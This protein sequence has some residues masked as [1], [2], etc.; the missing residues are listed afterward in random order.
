MDCVVNSPIGHFDLSS[1]TKFD[2]D[3][4]FNDPD[5]TNITYILNVCR[6]ITDLLCAP[7]SAIY[8]VNYTNPHLH[9]KWVDQIKS[10]YKIFMVFIL[11]INK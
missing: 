1:L 3:Y 11:D 9:L 2:N 6:P 7:D 4:Y 10:I 5:D 8:V